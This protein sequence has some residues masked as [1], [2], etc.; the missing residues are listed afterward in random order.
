[1]LGPTPSFFSLSY[2]PAICS[3][4]LPFVVCVLFSLEASR[5]MSLNT[6]AKL[7]PNL[8]TQW[9]AVYPSAGLTPEF[10]LT[11]KTLLM[12][13]E[14]KNIGLATDVYKWRWTCSAYAQNYPT[15]VLSPRGVR[16]AHTIMVFTFKPRFFHSVVARCLLCTDSIKCINQIKHGLLT[17]FVERI[18]PPE[19]EHCVQMPSAS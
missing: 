1:M 12:M 13:V 8:E 11:F 3:M 18:F 14:C 2:L 10:P 15:T 4:V 16:T 9:Q 19:L 5:S 7:L 6:D 17:S